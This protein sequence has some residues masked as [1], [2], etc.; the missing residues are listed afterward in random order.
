LGEASFVSRETRQ[1]RRGG[2]RDKKREP[3]YRGERDI[4]MPGYYDQ[5][6]EREK[7]GRRKRFGDLTA[8]EGKRKEKHFY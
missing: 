8:S 1:R 4:L 2:G 7:A 5:R 3:Y 6:M